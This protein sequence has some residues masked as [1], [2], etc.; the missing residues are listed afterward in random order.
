MCV[1]VC[2]VIK[3]FQSVKKIERG[4]GVL[5]KIYLI[6]D[7]ASKSEKTGSGGGG[8]GGR[9]CWGRGGVCVCGGGKLIILTN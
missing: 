5:G 3:E 4:E 9:G 2:G 6:F 1:C 7:K 8:G